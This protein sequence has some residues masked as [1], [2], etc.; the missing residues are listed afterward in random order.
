[1]NNNT[2]LKLEMSCSYSEFIDF[3]KINWNIYLFHED[4]VC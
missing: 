3:C 1:M 4:Y 2:W